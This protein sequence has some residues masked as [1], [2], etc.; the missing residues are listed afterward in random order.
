MKKD[1]DEIKFQ[2]GN[3]VKALLRNIN[4]NFKSVSFEIKRNGDLQI[5]I[6][7][8]KQTELEGEYIDDMMVELSALQINDRVLVPIVKIGGNHAPLENLVFQNRELD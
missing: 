7:L 3:I 1:M 8:Y 4:D 6:V 2:S 5:Q